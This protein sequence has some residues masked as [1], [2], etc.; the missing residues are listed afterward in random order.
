ME[1]NICVR[2]V[3]EKVLSRA[4]KEKNGRKKAFKEIVTEIFFQNAERH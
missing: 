3:L 1:D 2:R 4:Y